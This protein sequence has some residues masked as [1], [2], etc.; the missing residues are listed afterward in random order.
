MRLRKR[1]GSRLDVAR[2]ARRRLSESKHTPGR[3]VGVV[4][5]GCNV[6][7]CHAQASTHDALSPKIKLQKSKTCPDTTSIERSWEAGITAL[8]L[9]T[10]RTSQKRTLPQ[11][12][13]TGSPVHFCC[14]AAILQQWA[15]ALTG[16]R[17][18]RVANRTNRSPRIALN[19]PPT[20]VLSVQ[21]TNPQKEQCMSPQQAVVCMRAAEQE[22]A[23]CTESNMHARTTAT[24]ENGE[25]P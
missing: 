18:S 20:T 5:N 25:L 24:M 8:L 13:R 17:L 12:R 14:R 9:H 10:C 16:A 19:R 15:A 1:E 7:V 2:E 23:A 11:L 22:A 4:G 21:K 3:V 6:F